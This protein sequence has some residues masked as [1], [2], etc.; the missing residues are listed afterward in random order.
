M[1]IR[2]GA[3]ALCCDVVVHPWVRFPCFCFFAIVVFL[4]DGG[5]I[6]MVSE[7]S[8]LV[9]IVLCVCTCLVVV[10]SCLVLSCGCLVMS[11]VVVFCPHIF[12][13]R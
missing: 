12:I 13:S 5:D 10:L 4:L 7:P 8:V 9:F 11:C 3:D 1:F 6:L 2:E